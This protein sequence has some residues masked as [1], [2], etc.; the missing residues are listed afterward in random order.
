[1]VQSNRES[2]TGRPDLILCEKKFM[3][4]AI[5]LELKVAK[6]FAEMEAKCEEALAQIE[7]QDY[8]TPLLADGYRPILK[9]GIALY[10]KGCIVKKAE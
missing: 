9:Y 3:G 7:A 5:I 4:K 10:K 2:G 6:T 8:A 1:M